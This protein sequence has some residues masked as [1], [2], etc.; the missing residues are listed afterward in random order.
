MPRTAAN[1]KKTKPP[2]LAWFEPARRTRLEGADAA[3]A[4]LEHLSSA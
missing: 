3:R 2:L 4:W 1:T